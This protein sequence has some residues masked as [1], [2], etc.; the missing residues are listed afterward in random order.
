MPGTSTVLVTLSIVVCVPS[1]DDMILDNS[2]NEVADRLF[3]LEDELKSEPWYE[4]GYGVSYH[5]LTGDPDF[6]EKNAARCVVCGRWTTDVDQP[7]Q[8]ALILAGCL[9]DGQL[10]CE[11]CQN[12]AESSCPI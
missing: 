9:V 8:L 12:L 1:T 2:L 6:V 7:D 10:I 3:T 4:G 5:Y 11:E